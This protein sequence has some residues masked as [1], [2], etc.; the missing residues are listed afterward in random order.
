MPDQAM[1]K[2]LQRGDLQEPIFQANAL[3]ILEKRYLRRDHQG[4][5]MEDAKGMLMHR[6][7]PKSMSRSITKVLLKLRSWRE[8][9]MTAWQRVS[10]CPIRRL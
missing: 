5:I 9:F 2:Y 3:T 4:Q 7:S 10:S 1:D 6:V 8:P